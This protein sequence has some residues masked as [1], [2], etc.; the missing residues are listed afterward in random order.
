MTFNSQLSQRK[1]GSSGKIETEFALIIKDHPL[2][3]ARRI[4]NLSSILDYDLKHKRSFTIHD[5][6]FDTVSN[7]FTRHLISFRVRE[8]GR[9]TI[10]SIKSSPQGLLGGGTNRLELELLWSLESLVQIARRFHLDPPSRELFKQSAGSPSRVLAATGLEVIQNRL[11]RR[12]SRDLMAFRKGDSFRFAELSIDDVTYSFADETVRFL[13]VEIEA[14][15]A[16]A[17]PRIRRVVQHLVF[18]HPTLHVWAHGKF[19]TGLAIKK[20]LGRHR[21]SDL[22]IGGL[23]K[24]DAFGLI[25]RTVRSGSI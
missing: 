25:D 24:P 5:T 2:Q 11:T 20:L 16:G 4:A 19:V 15:A 10:L 1:P 9:R 22:T 18:E 8:F 21:L 23:I 13:E 12:R 17:L 3:N 7:Y 6:Y 14:K